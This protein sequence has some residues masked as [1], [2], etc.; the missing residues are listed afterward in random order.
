MTDITTPHI[1][2]RWRDDFTVTMRMQDASGEQIGDALATV[3][4]HCAESGESAEDA[5]GDPTDY[6]T[7]LVPEPVSGSGL[8]ATFLVGIFMGLLGLLMVPRAVED[9]AAGTQFAVTI[10]DLI[11]LAIVLGVSG[12]V[13]ALPRRVLPW[14]ARAKYS[15]FALAGVAIMAVLVLVSMVFLTDVVAELDWR[16]AL[17]IGIALL[18]ANVI[19]TWRALSTPDPVADPRSPEAPR[20]RTQWLTALMF[21]ILTV[22][23]VAINVL[24]P[25]SG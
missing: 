18:S 17:A 19:S 15:T 22:V 4:A 23:I 3:D 2:K 24:I 25:L 7:T 5:F 10:G 16:V 9:W 11:V 20:R 12:A 14:L 13:M 21:P 1:S 6:A 8:G